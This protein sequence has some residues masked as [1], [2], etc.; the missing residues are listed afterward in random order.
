MMKKYCGDFAAVEEM[1]HSVRGE[2]VKKNHQKLEQGGA[3]VTVHEG[4]VNHPSG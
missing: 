2:T 1:T 4:I 3:L